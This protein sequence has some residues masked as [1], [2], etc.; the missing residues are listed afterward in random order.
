MATILRILQGCCNSSQEYSA[1]LLM[2]HVLTW[3][4]LMKPLDY[5][6]IRCLPQSSSAVQSS[7]FVAYSYQGALEPLCCLRPCKLLSWESPTLVDVICNLQIDSCCQIISNLALLPQQ[8]QIKVLA[9]LGGSLGESAAKSTLQKSF[10]KYA[11]CP[12]TF[13]PAAIIIE[14]ALMIKMRVSVP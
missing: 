8:N 5:L 4:L 1:V 2:T 6:W 13:I 14:R 3:Q 11:T 12:R 9:T 7:S 10:L